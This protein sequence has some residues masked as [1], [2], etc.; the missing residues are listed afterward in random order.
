VRPVGPLRVNNG[1]AMMPL[2]VG[3]TGLGIL[4]DFIIRDALDDG[5]LEIVLPEWKVVGGSIHWVTPSGGRRP[6][7]V[8]ALSDFI[9]EKLSARRARRAEPA[10]A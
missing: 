5:R 6:K 7:R 9:A 4:P 3:G 10:P 1:D 8:D 2:L